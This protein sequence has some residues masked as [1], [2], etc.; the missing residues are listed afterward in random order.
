MIHIA[1]CDDDI[2]VTELVERLILEISNSISNKVEVTTFYSGTR[3]SKAIQNGCPFDI[4]F[5]DIEM[6]GMNGIK[7]GH[8]LRADDGNDLVRLI[9]ISSHEQYHVQLFD[10][11]PSGFIKK[12]I[13]PE[14][15]KHKLLST[16]QKV[17]RK[18]QLG[19]RNFLPVQQK[20]KEVL[21]PYREIMY[22]ES[23]IR[24]VHLYTRMDRIEYYST[25]NKEENKLPSSDF[26][27]IH[28]SYIVNFYF[29]REISYKK[30]T[31]I[32]GL[33]LPISMKNSA[34]VKQNYLK[35]RG[36]LIE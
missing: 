8:L 14:L 29:I 4:I 30:V 24:K 16:M 6:D 18:R 22:L 31:L 7:A 25:L 2:Q 9:Y 11:Q 1:I 5:M 10:V 12:P 28:Q 33:E 26:I 34:S 19:I 23:R 35:F 17:I 21:V 32:T 13:Q 15:F 20:G 3:F 27:R 36:T